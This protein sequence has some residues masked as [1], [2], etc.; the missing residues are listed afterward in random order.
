[1]SKRLA[2]WKRSVM[3]LAMGGS[4]F[5]F[6]L[7]NQLFNCDGNLQNA[8]LETFYRGAGNGFI[9]AEVSNA[10]TSGTNAGI[11]GSDFNATFQQPLTR[12]AQA[13]WSNFVFL[14]FPKDA[15][16]VNLLEQ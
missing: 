13:Y 4:T 12:L 5:G 3:L 2:G 10:F 7:G 1:M 14:Q 16:P 6:G 11:F 9:G 15:P 8:D